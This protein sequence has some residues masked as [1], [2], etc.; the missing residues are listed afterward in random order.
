M[1]NE[2]TAKAAEDISAIQTDIAQMNQN[3]SE[4]RPKDC[5]D[6]D[7][8]DSFYDMCPQ[9]EHSLFTKVSVSTTTMN[10]RT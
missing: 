10:A 2:R 4:M 1:L 3:I 7:D 6:R 8:E 9:P 5:I